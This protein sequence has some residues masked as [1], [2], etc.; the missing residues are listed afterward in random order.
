MEI[1]VQKWDK[2]SVFMIE[3]ITNFLGMNLGR[4]TK[5]TLWKLQCNGGKTKEDI[6]IGKIPCSWIKILNFFYNDCTPKCNLQRQHNLHKNFSLLIYRN[7]QFDSKMH[8]GFQD[9]K[10]R[11]NRFE[12]EL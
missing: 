11:Q 2:K 7:L 10:N 1:T 9:T 12:R 6:I 5:L 3:E 8:M 4:S